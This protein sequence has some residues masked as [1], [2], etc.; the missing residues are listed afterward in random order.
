MPFKGVVLNLE[1]FA[2]LAFVTVFISTF[3][4]ATCNSGSNFSSQNFFLCCCR[5]RVMCSLRSRLASQSFDL[6]FR[7]HRSFYP[8]SIVEDLAQKLKS[9]NSKIDYNLRKSRAGVILQVTRCPSVAKFSWSIHC[10]DIVKR[11]RKR[12]HALQVLRKSGLP[13]V[14]LFQVYCS[15]ERPILEFASLVWA[16]LPACLVPLVEGVQ[17]SALRITFPD[18]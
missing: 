9:A 5:S 2:R 16:A 6:I 11:A 12:L 14:D 17:K 3:Y 10:D 13:S 8:S 1:S 7:S 4:S 15:L 18:C